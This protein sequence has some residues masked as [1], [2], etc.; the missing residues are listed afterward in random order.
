MAEPTNK[1]RILLLHL[2]LALTTF[3]VFYQVCNH[4]FINYDDPGYVTA[5]HHVKAGLTPRTIAWAFTTSHA[6][7]WHPL[8]WLSHMLDCHLFRTNPRWH[9]LTNLLLHIMNTLLLFAVLRR[10]TLALWHSA[11]VAAAFALHPLHVQSVAWIAERK[12][13]LST[14]FWM[15]TMAAYLRYIEHPRISRY[16][17]T[18][19]VFALGLMAKPMLVSL[20][21]VLI[22]LDYWPLRRLQLRPKNASK[23]LPN[24]KSPTPTFKKL[25]PSRLFVEKISLFVL[26]VLSS[27][28]TLIVQQKGGAIK[29]AETFSW[30]V[31]TA[32]ALIAYVTYIAKTIWPARLAI[33][34]PHPGRA[35]S[36]SQALLAALL[37]LAISAYV[38]WLART[39]KYL[40]V[41]WLW[42]LGTLVPVIG[43][44]QVG[45]Q[46][47]ADR[48][49]Y[50]PLIGLFIIVAWGV[51][52][53]L[54]KYQY[55]K[56][57]FTASAFAVLLALSICTHLQLRHWRNSITVFEHAIEVTENNRMAHSNL[58]VALLNRRRPDDAI[59]HFTAALQID[60]NHAMTHLNLGVALFQKRKYDAAVTSFTQA[61]RIDPDLAEA[62][63]NLGIVLAKQ[64][65]FDQ[66]VKHYTQALQI[67]PHLVKP[68]KL[69]KEAL[70]QLNKQQ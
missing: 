10:M 43:L 5:N 11:F 53:L 51:P 55:R 27:V 64:K 60:P 42:Y 49:T 41:G 2:A 62:H 23:A 30:I 26:A 15:L 56:I 25:P 54:A 22:L 7:N 67:K 63:V 13:V 21:F 39:R 58:G 14:L 20:P 57:L 48:Y 45:N 47:L 31:R 65:K 69:R 38:V 17:L 34:Y 46:A 3:A 44:V 12:D 50:I 29:T 70:L 37:L 16:L 52:D 68:Q 18:L 40:L 28:I 35:V 36:M 32:N 8:T 59:T 9:H 6:G 4:A 66:A 24:P 61:L 1:Y 33:F 19:L